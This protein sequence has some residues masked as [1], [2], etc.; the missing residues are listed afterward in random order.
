MYGGQ[1]AAIEVMY[2]TSI[3]KENRTKSSKEVQAYALRFL[4]T[5]QFAHLLTHTMNVMQ[6]YEVLLGVT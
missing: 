6:S 1:S 5:S 3:K 4:I 2:R